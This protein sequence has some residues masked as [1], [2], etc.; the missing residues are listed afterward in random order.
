MTDQDH[1]AGE[2]S[3]RPEYAGGN[4]RSPEEAILIKDAPSH[5][6]GVR[7]ES[8][9]ISRKFGERGQDWKLKGQSLTEREDGRQIDQMTIETAAG[10]V[11][12]FYFDVSSFFG[13]D[14]PD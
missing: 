9:Y 6:A 14:L 5:A 7:A 12:T 2:E 11:E 8:T 10:D 1:F 13:M 3:D 4:G